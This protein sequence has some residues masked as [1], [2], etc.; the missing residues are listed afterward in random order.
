MAFL[1]HLIARLKEGMEINKG[2]EDLIDPYY[3]QGQR[4]TVALAQPHNCVLSHSCWSLQN[5]S[6]YLEFSTT[7]AACDFLSEDL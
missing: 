5:A 1:E 7:A 4:R 6:H 3:C 2:G